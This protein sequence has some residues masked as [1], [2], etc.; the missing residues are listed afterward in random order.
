MID[1]KKI[2]SILFSEPAFRKKQVK[3]LVLCDL[4][5]SWDEATTLSK[6]LRE[7]LKKEVALEINAKIFPSDDKRTVRALFVFEDE[8]KAEAVLMRHLGRNTVCVSSQIGCALGCVFCATGKL[9]FK[10]NL[11]SGEIVEQVLFWARR[12][13]KEKQRV[14]NIV[15]MGMG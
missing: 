10:R 13:K 6:T 1:F 12:L 5:E 2:D 4:I 15:F 9:G 14:N 8:Q 3:R 11:T 7:L